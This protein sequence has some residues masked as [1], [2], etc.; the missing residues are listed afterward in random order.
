M[1]TVKVLVP[2]Q[3]G[4]NQIVGL[5]SPKHACVPYLLPI[6]FEEATNLLAETPDVTTISRSDQR[7]PEGHVAVAVGSGGSYGAEDEMESDKTAVSPLS[8]CALVL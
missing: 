7:T 2:R 8:P 3:F 5:L 1:A 4:P 6:E